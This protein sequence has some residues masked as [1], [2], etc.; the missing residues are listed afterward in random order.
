MKPPPE[1]TRYMPND[2]EAAITLTPSGSQPAKSHKWPGTV[3][4]CASMR[5]KLRRGNRREARWRG[6]GHCRA[7]HAGFRYG[8]RCRCRDRLLGGL[9]R[10]RTDDLCG[11]GGTDVA[12]DHTE[13]SHGGYRADTDSRRPQLP[14]FCLHLDHSQ[15]GRW[16]T[17]PPGRNPQLCAGPE[18]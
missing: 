16:F 13:R 15:S 10:D 14:L 6:R 9:R 2:H 4:S 5:Q 8:R 3:Q 1:P 17:P 12:E 11:R 18:S 7:R